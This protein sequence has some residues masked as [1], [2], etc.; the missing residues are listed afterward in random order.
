MNKFEL[1]SMGENYEKQCAK[2]RRKAISEVFTYVQPAVPPQNDT[3]IRSKGETAE[4]KKDAETELCK[5]KAHILTLTGKLESANAKIE[6][7]QQTVHDMEFRVENVN[8]TDFCF[9]TGFPSRQI[10]NAVLTY[11]NPG[12]NGE[13]VV[14]T[15]KESRLV[16]DSI[17]LRKIRR[18]RKV[19]PYKSG[20]FN[21]LAGSGLDPSD[22][23]LLKDVT[24][25]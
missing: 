12:H 18:P 24:F 8:D 7:H 6:Q 13:N 19:T 5:L 14:Y 16:V 4:L 22:A 23:I 10:Y 9:Y 2:T 20:F 21:S 3:F 15:R 25:L 1:R 17:L 11:L